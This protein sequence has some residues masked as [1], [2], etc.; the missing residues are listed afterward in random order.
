MKT[1][2]DFGWRRLLLWK[3][4]LLQLVSREV[5]L[6]MRML[7]LLADK[8][9][10]IEGMKLSRFDKTLGLHRQRIDTIYRGLEGQAAAAGMEAPPTVPSEAAT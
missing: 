7:D 10:G 9:P 4:A 3:P 1:P 5:T 6:D 2:P 8:R